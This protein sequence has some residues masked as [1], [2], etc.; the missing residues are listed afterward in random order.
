MK[1]RRSFPA[2]LGGREQHACTKI[3]AS[4]RTCKGRRGHR[5]D[6]IVIW[7]PPRRC[8]RVESVAVLSFGVVVFFGRANQAIFLNTLLVFPLRCRSA[9]RATQVGV[10]SS[11][12]SSC[13]AFTGRR[14]FDGHHPKHS[15]PA[16]SNRSEFA[17]HN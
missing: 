17:R 9:L 8:D 15:E 16:R 7:L 4:A 1:K 13:S 14:Q 10:T 2:A 11:S 6:E 12:S 3:T 5:V